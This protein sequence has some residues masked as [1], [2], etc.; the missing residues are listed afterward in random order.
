MTRSFWKSKSISKFK[1]LNK[2]LIRIWDRDIYISPMF[3]NLKI[4]VYNGQK[5]VPF[6]FKNEMIGHKLGEFIFTRKKCIHKK[7]TVKLK[8]K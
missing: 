4:E 2:K 1:S 7:K 8:K 6:Y 5:F 3:N